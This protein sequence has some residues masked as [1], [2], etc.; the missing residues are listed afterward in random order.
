MRLTQYVLYIVF[1]YIVYPYCKGRNIR[2]TIYLAILVYQILLINIPL[3]TRSY[4][5]YTRH[6]FTYIGNHV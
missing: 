4:D 1:G 3:T 6:N 2:F 5:V